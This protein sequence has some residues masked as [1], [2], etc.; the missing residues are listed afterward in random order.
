MLPETEKI[1]RSFYQPYNDILAK[2]VNDERYQWLDTELLKLQR[3]HLKTQEQEHLNILNDE[4]D[5]KLKRQQRID[6][7]L[8]D[9]PRED[10]D[11]GAGQP[12]DPDHI[13]VVLPRTIHRDTHGNIIQFDPNDHSNNNN[14]QAHDH[15]GSNNKYSPERE[16]ALNLKKQRLMSLE[17]ALAD[18]KLKQRF[19]DLRHHHP[20]TDSSHS[21]DTQTG[22]QT[23]EAGEY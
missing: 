9:Y 3:K 8:P 7:G 4:K 2:F 14:N 23:E 1:L 10:D 13:H 5:L 19:N 20:L 6:R 11:E 16:A 15:G 18:T 12:F 21:S 17:Q 22:L